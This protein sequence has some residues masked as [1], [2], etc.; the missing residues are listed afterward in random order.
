MNNFLP[1]TSTIVP[2]EVERETNHLRDHLPQ[3]ENNNAK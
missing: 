2:S 1:E 3:A